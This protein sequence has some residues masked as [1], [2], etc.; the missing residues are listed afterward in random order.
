MHLREPKRLPADCEL[1]VHILLRTTEQDLAVRHKTARRPPTVP[2]VEEI[3]D[4]RDVLLRIAVSITRGSHRSFSPWAL[5]NF[6]E[7]SRLQIIE[8]KRVSI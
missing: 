4:D 3:V 6:K 5:I 2:R 8:R 7:L 1:K